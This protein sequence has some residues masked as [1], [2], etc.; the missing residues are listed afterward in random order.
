[1]YPA[2]GSDEQATENDQKNSGKH[3]DIP[4]PTNFSEKDVVFFDKQG[5]I[6]DNDDESSDNSKQNSVDPEIA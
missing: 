4:P 3:I 1:M 6:V 5:N 2:V